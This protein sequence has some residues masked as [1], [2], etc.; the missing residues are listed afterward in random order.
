MRQEVPFFYKQWDELPLLAYLPHLVL[1]VLTI[2]RF[3]S[4]LHNTPIGKEQKGRGQRFGQKRV[5]KTGTNVRKSV[6]YN[7]KT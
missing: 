2:D 4:E 1:P 6:D 5:R 7:S 3:R